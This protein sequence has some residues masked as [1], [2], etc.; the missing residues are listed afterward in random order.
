MRQCASYAP[1]LLR[2]LT[3]EG[4]GQTQSDLYL[5]YST[6][7][8]PADF[9]SRTASSDPRAVLGVRRGFSAEELKAAFRKTA[10]VVHP[11]RGG[12]QDMFDAVT[13]AFKNLTVEL[14]NRATDEVSGV[15]PMSV[16][17]VQ[18]RRKEAAAAA[19]AVSVSDA[20]RERLHQNFHQ[21]F[22]ET[23]VRSRLDDHGYERF[24]RGGEDVE[25]AD[26]SAD[27]ADADAAA[28]PRKRFD[29]RFEGRRARYAR[30][31]VPDHD[32]LPAHGLG[33]AVEVG[34]VVPRDMS[35]E[36]STSV[37][38]TDLVQAHAERRFLVT[39]DELA[40]MARRERKLGSSADPEAARKFLN[41]AY[42][43][44]DA[45]RVAERAKKTE[46]MLREREHA[47]L[48][49]EREDLARAAAIQGHV[50]RRMLASG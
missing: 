15:M 29:A 43:K 8:D 35:V 50:A 14:R 34:S 4:M 23:H 32:P 37:V 36:V 17:D 44:V 27:D 42:K 46:A 41:K 2:P 18:R 45:K 5:Q 12:T 7:P 30:A 13:E 48:T 19:T 33:G 21:I 39:P 10:R 1:F 20:A 38:G 3:K 26:A 47:A 31:I 16:D 25:D 24:L 40:A 6:S 49:S 9:A 28:D 22:E 11:D